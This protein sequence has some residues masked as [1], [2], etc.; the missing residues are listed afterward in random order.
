MK[1]HTHVHLHI[2]LLTSSGMSTSRECRAWTATENTASLLSSRA[3]LSSRGTST[4]S[5]LPT[6]DPS[7]TPAYSPCLPRWV[8][9]ARVLMAS[10]RC[11]RMLLRHRGRSSLMVYPAAWSNKMHN[12]VHVCL[13]CDGQGQIRL[14]E[15][16]I[17]AHMRTCSG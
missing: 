17:L 6:T 14:T 7:M 3:Y 12:H 13:Y 15:L 9:L 16:T 8:I 4:S 1:L 10:T 5:S 11:W 2:N